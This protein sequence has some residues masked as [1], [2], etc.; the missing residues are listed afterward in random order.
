MSCFAYVLQ[1]VVCLFPALQADTPAKNRIDGDRLFA[2][3]RLVEIRIELPKPDWD[4]L[5]VQA[6]NTGAIF[7]G[8]VE[9]NP[10]DYFKADLWIDETKIEAVGVRKKG[11]LGS[12]DTDRPSLKVKFDEFVKQDPVDGLS[13]LTLNNNKQDKS[14]LSQFLTYRLFRDARIHAPRSSLARVTVNG[15]D[16]GIYSNVESIKKSFLDRSFGDRTGNLYEGTLTDFHPKTIDRIEVKTNDDTNDRSDVRR[17]AELLATDGE[18]NPEQIGKLVNVDNFIRYWAI[19][20]MTRFWD[21]YAS[22]QN[23]FYFYIF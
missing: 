6:R 7:S 8:V 5:R 15:Q 20:G 22:N 13:R 2:P 19:E 14:Q 18:L 16:L 21:G 12:A 1:V 4:K 17:L 9:E 3:D 11:F 10:Y 23:N